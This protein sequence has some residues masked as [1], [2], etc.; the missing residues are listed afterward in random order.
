MEYKY[1]GYKVLQ[2]DK[3]LILLLDELVKDNENTEILEEVISILNKSTSKDKTNLKRM[4]QLLK[5]GLY[6]FEK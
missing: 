5:L 1:A 3:S 2:A 6:N 4:L